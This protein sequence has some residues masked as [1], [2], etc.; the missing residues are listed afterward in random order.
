MGYSY[1]WASYIC[2][3][4]AVKA[5]CTQSMATAAAAYRRK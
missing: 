1:S 5:T 3:N 4:V 2:K